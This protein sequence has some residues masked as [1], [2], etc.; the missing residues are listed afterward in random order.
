MGAGWGEFIR[1]QK[2][3]ELGVH[4]LST[5]D[6][7]GMAFKE[8]LI[9]AAAGAGGLGATRVSQILRDFIVPPPTAHGDFSEQ[10]AEDLIAAIKRGEFSDDIA[11]I[12]RVLD[13]SGSAHRLKLDPAALSQ[14]PM[15]LELRDAA[16]QGNRTLKARHAAAVAENQ[17]ALDDYGKVLLGF[18]LDATPFRPGVPRSDLGRDVQAR[19]RAEANTIQAEADTNLRLAAINANKPLAHYGRLDPD[20]AG[21]RAGEIISAY[22]NGLRAVK[23][24]AYVMYSR[25]IG[26]PVAGDEGFT[27][28]TRLTSRIQVPV[29]QA[30][31][32][33]AKAQRTIKRAS[34]LTEAVAGE[35]ALKI[36]P[37]DQ[38][39][40]RRIDLALLDN[41]IKWL[42]GRIDAKDG[43]FPV[44]R[45]I[46]AK[47]VLTQM[48]EDFLTANH[49]DVLHLLNKAQIAHGEYQDFLKKGVLSKIISET[50]DG[51]LVT[52]NANA[53]KHIFAKENTQALRELMDIAKEVPGGTSQLEKTV[54][55]IYKANVAPDGVPMLD[56]HQKFV[57]EH[58]GQL[59]AVF[60]SN[61]RV[62]RFGELA[63]IVDTH[64]AQAKATREALSK[65]ALARMSSKEPGLA[66][67]VGLNTAGVSP[68]LLGN[69]V[70]LRGTSADD[71][72]EVVRV[73]ET[74][75]R[76]LKAFQQSVG[77]QMYE[78]LMPGGQL[79][80]KAIPK[81]VERGGNLEKLTHV[82]G[83]QYADDL[84]KLW[85]GMLLNAA[86]IGSP[87]VEKTT[88]FGLLARTMITPPLTKRGRAQTFVEHMRADA[89]SEAIYN[90]I[91]SPDLLHALV[92]QGN[93]DVRSRGVMS[94]FSQMSALS[95]LHSMDDGELGL[96]LQ[97]LEDK[98]AAEESERIRSLAE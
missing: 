18:D 50:P 98:I 60:G 43:A 1:L 41:N 32:D 62:F 70:L 68:E 76:L 27:Q 22:G 80:M 28:A 20:T 92:A 56:L 5:E 95:A 40:R 33:F 9:D 44:E 30:F 51:V 73:L 59:E 45:L 24:D 57:K 7:M 46:A 55:Q 91:T 94:V 31:A 53:F 69:R 72:L 2:G 75:P 66:G 67:Q 88:P 38:I 48:R 71:V 63:K 81:F 19:L 36:I 83:E 39:G 61:A 26:Q 21:A 25:A 17:A 58:R 82:F 49:P 90:A 13:D 96:G 11:T 34:L 12:N 64:A 15:A 84:G 89:I 87:K 93:K 8:L 42:N 4:D 29:D 79:N 52:S 78:Q 23:D 54:L 65:S 86:K 3:K 16:V 97:G 37:K 10:T 77:R 35:N 6:M 74:D 85:R 47:K 14:D